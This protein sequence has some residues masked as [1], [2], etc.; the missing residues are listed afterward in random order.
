[1][2]YYEQ[3]SNRSRFFLTAFAVLAFVYVAVSIFLQRVTDIC[4]AGAVFLIALF[5]T[6]QSYATV[7]IDANGI[8]YR[9]FFRTRN[10][11][12]NRIHRWS[13]KDLRAG[14]GTTAVIEIISQTNTTLTLLYRREL[15]RALRAHASTYFT[16]PTET[17]QK[18]RRP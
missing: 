6:L 1:M 9:Q 18:T 12:W 7:K 13:I 15:E 5:F 16:Q 11:A 10:I 2:K 3:I 17:K 8:S 4:I 14:G